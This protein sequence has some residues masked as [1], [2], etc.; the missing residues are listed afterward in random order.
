[1]VHR[2]IM[3]RLKA[4]ILKPPLILLCIKLTHITICKENSHRDLKAIDQKIVYTKNIYLNFV[5]M[6]YYWKLNL[7]YPE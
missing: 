1:M 4:T 6:Q 2:V 7:S 3:H 5:T